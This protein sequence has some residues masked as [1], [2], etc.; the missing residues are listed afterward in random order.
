MLK[1]ELY[2]LFK[3]K[4]VWVLLLVLLAYA[5][6]TDI[7]DI[8]DRDNERMQYEL[9]QYEAAKGILTD[10]RLESFYKDYEPA[11]FDDFEDGFVEDG[12]LKRYLRFT[13][14]LILTSILVI[15]PTGPG[16][17]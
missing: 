13:L 7:T 11:G 4:L 8:L 10:E 3:R 5:L 14:I 2:K 12:K 15:P 9:E 6:Y 1:L 17:W 16:G